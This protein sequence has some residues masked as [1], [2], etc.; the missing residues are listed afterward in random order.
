MKR[1]LHS[2]SVLILF[3]ILLLIICSLN[4]KARSKNASGKVWLK[5]E[6]GNIA[7]YPNPF[8]ESLKLVFVAKCECDYTINMTDIT[9]RSV[10]KDKFTARE[11]EVIKTIG[12]LS[13]FPHGTYIITLSNGTDEPM[14]VK[15]EH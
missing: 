5:T 9:G 13:E 8:K 6:T 2:F 15:L 7:V 11:G 1:L 12:M 4:A 14:R 3:S 10:Y